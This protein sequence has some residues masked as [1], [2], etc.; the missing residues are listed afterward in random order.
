MKHK[1]IDSQSQTLN[2][3]W[4]VAQAIKPGQQTGLDLKTLYSRF[5]FLKTVFIFYAL[6]STP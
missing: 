5:C 3:F 4:T 6:H 1:R 2:L